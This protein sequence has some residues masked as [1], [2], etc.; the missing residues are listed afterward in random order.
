MLTFPRISRHAGIS[1]GQ[2]PESQPIFSLARGLGGSADVLNCG[3]CL[4]ALAQNRRG[5]T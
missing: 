4:G 1:Y 2:G 5:V 3:R